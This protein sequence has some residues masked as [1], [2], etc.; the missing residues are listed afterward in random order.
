MK[1]SISIFYSWQSG[2]FDK[3][4]HYLIG[5]CLKEA[6]K[7]LAPEGIS[8]QVDQDTRDTTGAADI[9]Q[10]V[11]PKIEN[12]H[13]FVGDV[14]IIN[15]NTKTERK[16]PNPNV[17]LELG[18]AAGTLGWERIISILNLKTGAPED[19]PFD[20]RHRRIT[21]YDSSNSI[22][23]VKKALTAKLVSAIKNAPPLQNKATEQEQA[24]QTLAQMLALAF[25]CAWNFIVTEEV[26]EADSKITT[27]T[28]IS[29]YEETSM[30][31][32]YHLMQ[33][34]S[35]VPS[36]AGKRPRPPRRLAG[37]HP[38]YAQRHR[39]RLWMGV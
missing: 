20:I 16:T 14:S 5:D 23:D 3:E 21:R 9:P 30:V 1:E 29:D 18:Y 4:N 19:L 26:E 17:M 10:I 13:L 8:V 15:P 35:F 7:R 12:A 34:E 28:M 2:Q 24:K 27:I 38:K 37:D 33:A 39:R 11:F 22:E 25:R 31:L 6:V 32:E 36:P